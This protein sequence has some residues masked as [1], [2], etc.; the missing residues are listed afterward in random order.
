MC[1]H[2]SNVM[3]YKSYCHKKLILIIMIM[4]Y[5]YECVYCLYTTMI[6]VMIMIRCNYITICLH[7][8]STCSASNASQIPSYGSANSSECEAGSFF[9]ATEVGCSLC[10]AGTIQTETGQTSCDE[11][12]PGS[13][14]SA[15]GATECVLCAIA[16]YGPNTGAASCLKCPSGRST[17]L[18]GSVSVDD[19]ISPLPNYISGF[20]ALL[21]GVLSCVIY[22][23]YGR[24]HRVGFL[25]GERPLDYIIAEAEVVIQQLNSV[26]KLSHE[27]QAVKQT[28]NSVVKLILFVIVSCILLAGAVLL[29]YAD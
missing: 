4:I 26:M 17:P 13:F 2:I 20:I 3:C 10:P 8:I 11:C 14:A 15:P 28:M 19:C 1:V 24:V 27:V 16:F 5:Y 23:A 21:V 18:V 6:L 7:I 9:D 12:G 29:V 25:R 22:F